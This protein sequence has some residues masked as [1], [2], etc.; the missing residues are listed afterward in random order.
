MLKFR[1]ETKEKLESHLESVKIQLEELEDQS[2]YQICEMDTKIEQ[3]K[4]KNC[5]ECQSNKDLLKIGEEIIE[6]LS[7]IF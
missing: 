5:I 7:I 6:K 3:M 1:S 4:N 2:S